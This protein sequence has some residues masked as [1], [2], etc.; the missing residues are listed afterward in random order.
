MKTVRN[1]G[2][3]AVRELPYRLKYQ[4]FGSLIPGAECAVIMQSAILLTVV[5]P[6]AK[7]TASSI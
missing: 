6:K 4:S 1:F 7:L 3:L 2:N 5:A